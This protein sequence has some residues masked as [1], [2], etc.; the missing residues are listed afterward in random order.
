MH[1]SPIHLFS[2]S[3][4]VEEC[5]GEIR[6]CLEE[7]WTGWGAKCI[8]FE[9]AWRH[10]ARLKNAHFLNSA[11]AGLHLAVR[12]LKEA[13]RWHDQDEIIAT[14]LTFPSTNH[15]VLYENLTPVFADV[16]E[17]LCLNPDSVRERISSRTRA[18]CYVGLGGN[19]GR[20]QEIRE[21]CNEHGLSLILDAAHMAGT[22]L[23]SLHAG[24]D[25]DASVFSFQAVKNV[26]T[27]DS[28][29]VC[30]ADDKLDHDA[31]KWSWL[32]IDKDTFSRTHQDGQYSWNY[33]VEVTGYKYQGNSV[34]AA[35]GLVALQY[36]EEDNQRRREI[37]C[38]Y[39]ELLR[40]AEGVVRVPMAPDTTPSRH[41]YQV[42]VA[43]RDNVIAAMNHD[44]IFPG[45]HYRDNTEYPMYAYGSG[46]CPAARRASKSI[47]SLP[48]H[49][50]LTP[51][52]VVR[53]T[54]SLIRSVVAF[55]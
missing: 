44:N 31:R 47:I 46:T 41:L 34:M 42:V 38:W 23:G 13:G 40:S 53:V 5:L 45:V 35:L 2:P 4:R 29:M 10:Y 3:Y 14:P 18:V 43:H 51:A 15:A 8:Q 6:Q 54:E 48:I 32:G 55:S 22:W 16:D 21:I 37:A 20:Y 39:D 25:A 11:T 30:F 49:P 36:L 50:R 26:P 27:A 17:F 28:G 33:N 12:L 52:D 19:P 9:C 24:T 1:A 7:G